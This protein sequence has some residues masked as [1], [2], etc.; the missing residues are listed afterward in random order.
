[1]I[2]VPFVQTGAAFE[3]FNKV[4]ATTFV[5][6]VMESAT[7]ADPAEFEA[8]TVYVDLGD[9]DVGAPVIIPFVTESVSPEG[10]AG[11]T[12]KAVGTPPVTVATFGTMAVP[13][14]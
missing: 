5:S 9:V 1:V 8:V 6:T 11:F 3:Y 14:V 10:R 2:N 13:T 12:A 4:G 7:V